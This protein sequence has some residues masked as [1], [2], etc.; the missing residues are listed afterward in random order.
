MIILV[1]AAWSA[2]IWTVVLWLNMKKNV[3][4]NNVYQNIVYFWP[5]TPGQNDPIQSV[6]KSPVSKMCFY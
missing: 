1:V 2:A 4:I 5:L 6:W 3:Q